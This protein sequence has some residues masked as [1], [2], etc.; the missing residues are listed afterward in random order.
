[1]NK[2][3]FA[4]NQTEFNPQLKTY[5][6]N[7]AV[8][9]LTNT[10]GINKAN[11]ISISTMDQM[12]NTNRTRMKHLLLLAKTIRPKELTVGGTRLGKNLIMEDNQSS[13]SI[14][15]RENNTRA[16]PFRSWK[17]GNNMSVDFGQN[18]D[19]KIRMNPLR[20]I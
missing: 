20:N 10:F 2:S 13:A 11:Q 3:K 19:D 16:L 6:D 12:E 8:P 7:I 9:Y 4:R 15:R 18:A 5:L 17:S 1:M 14:A